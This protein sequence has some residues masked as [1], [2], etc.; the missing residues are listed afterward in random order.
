[1]KI[2]IIN[3]THFG[4]RGD[5][6][7]FLDHQETFFR[8]I[9]FPYLDEH[10]IKHVMDLG[11]TF[12]RRKYIN[13]VTLKRVKEFFFNQLQSRGIEYHAVVGNHSVYFTNTNEVNSMN[14]LL[15]EYNNF[16]IY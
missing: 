16:H 8:D 3:D 5:S 10:G 11:D 9:F 7:I 12:D 4:V 1:M 6:K 2:A 13:Y 14:L 15:Q